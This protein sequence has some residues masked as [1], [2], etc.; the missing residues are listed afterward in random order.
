MLGPDVM[1]ASTLGGRP[2]ATL[3]ALGAAGWYGEVKW[4]GIRAVVAQ[5]GGQVRIYNRRR[6]DITARYPDVVSALAGTFE[7]ILDGEIICLGPQGRPDFAA[8]HRRDAQSSPVAIVHLARTHPAKF[9]PF[10]VLHDGGL[11]LHYSVQEWSYEARRARLESMVASA[12][13]SSRDLPTLW[14][15]VVDHNLEGLVLKR[16]GSAYRSGRQKAWVK[17]KATK[18]MCAIVTGVTP[19]KNG[20]TI[21]SL[22]I[23]VWDEQGRQMVGIGHVGSGMTEAD[24][25]GL[26]QRMAPGRPPVVVEVEYLEV[27]NT[28]QLRMPVYK[29]I[30]DDVHPTQVTLDSLPMLM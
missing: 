22:R 21:G 3:E 6:T 11:A 13:A 24:L 28:G 8:V 12:P 16:P 18:R 25:R 14:S 1:L 27:G 7:G 15:F 26:H 5:E 29:G 30:R 19:G 10:D 23:G 20:R 2:E 4:D 17:V 9:M